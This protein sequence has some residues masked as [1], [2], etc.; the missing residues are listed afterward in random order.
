MPK[1]LVPVF[2]QVKL[3]KNTE[4]ISSGIFISEIEKKCQ[5]Y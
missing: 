5:N 2:L 4:T 1:L 3:K